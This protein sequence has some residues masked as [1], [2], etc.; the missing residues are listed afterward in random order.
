MK[1][2]DSYCVSRAL[3][4]KILCIG[5]NFFLWWPVAPY[6]FSSLNAVEFEGNFK[7]GS[8]ILGK[9]KPKAKI[10]ID[11]KDNSGV[12]KNIYIQDNSNKNKT[13]V[14]LAKRGLLGKK[15]DNIYLIL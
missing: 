1:K 14:V 8:F 11:N 9:T 2:K 4:I 7:Q 3:F 15:N 13:Q 5:L 12:F 6:F 10:F